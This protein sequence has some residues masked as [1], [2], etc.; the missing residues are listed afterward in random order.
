LSHTEAHDPATRW[1]VGS[2][3]LWIAL[4]A[5]CG[6]CSGAAAQQEILQ[7]PPWKQMYT[8]KQGNYYLVG[9]PVVSGAE[10]KLQAMNK[11]MDAAAVIFL[12]FSGV[13]LQGKTETKTSQEV[14][15]E[16][17]EGYKEEL[18]IF[19]RSQIEGVLRRATAKEQR[20]ACETSVF[21]KPNCSAAVWLQVPASEYDRLVEA[22]EKGPALSLLVAMN[23]KE[24]RNGDPVT[25]TVTTNRDAHV[26]VL[27]LNMKDGWDKIFPNQCS[28]HDAVRENEELVLPD[29]KMKAHPCDMTFLAQLMEGAT[30]SRETMQVIAACDPLGDLTGDQLDKKACEGRD[31][32]CCVRKVVSYKITGR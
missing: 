23:Q 21:S 27:A 3:H 31:G 1:R 22:R 29:D 30:N 20:S 16:G 26:A 13:K 6:A 5:L 11:A 25:I 28:K 24:Y 17:V 14:S 19:T 4:A 8:Q 10:T 15:R 12:R 7:K 18:N 32:D 9:G 2:V